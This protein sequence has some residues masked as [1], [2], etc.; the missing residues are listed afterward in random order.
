M[1]KIE[2]NLCD[3]NSVLTLL[4][5]PRYNP[6]TVNKIAEN[7]RE[8]KRDRFDMSDELQV[9]DMEK[10]ESSNNQNIKVFEVAKDETLTQVYGSKNKN[11]ELHE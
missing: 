3:I 8:I 6:K 7:H 4:N 2:V 10:L 11:K 1:K 9:I 5:P